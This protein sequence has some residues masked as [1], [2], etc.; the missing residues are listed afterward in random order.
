VQTSPLGA[1]KQG[2][3]QIEV[4]LADLPTGLFHYTFMVNGEKQIQKK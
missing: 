4:S 3:Y 2:I 1:R